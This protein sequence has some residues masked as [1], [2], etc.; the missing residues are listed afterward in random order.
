MTMPPD[1]PVLHPDCPGVGEFSVGTPASMLAD[2]DSEGD[3]EGEGEGMP[4]LALAMEEP[5]PQ[6]A[7]TS[8]V[9]AASMIASHRQAEAN[10]IDDR[11]ESCIEIRHQRV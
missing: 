7:S 11:F 4:L 9:A 8:A 10:G 5:P 6:A 2:G 3:A 1:I